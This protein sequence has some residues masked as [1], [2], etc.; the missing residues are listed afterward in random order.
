MVERL[1]KGPKLRVPS[2]PHWGGKRLAVTAGKV[3]RQLG[4]ERFA[5][6]VT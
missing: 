4:H 2:L 1:L 3:G 6:Y 5:F